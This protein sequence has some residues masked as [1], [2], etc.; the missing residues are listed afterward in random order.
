M[1]IKAI[2]IDDEMNN[3]DNLNVLLSG[4]CP[5]VEVVATAFSA[6][7]GRASILQY[8]PDLVFLDIQMPDK[9]GFELL[10]SLPQYDFEV[11]FVTAYDQ[12]GIQAVKFSAIDYLLKPINVIELQE[13]VSRAISK[14]RRSKQNLQLENLVQ[15]MM[16]QKEEHRIAL[17]TQKE[18][19]FVPTEEIIRCESSNNYTSFFLDSGEKIIV[20]KPIYDFEEIL[21]S[22]GFIRCHQSH[23]V[24]KRYIKSWV[25]E[26]GGY[27]MTENGTPIP[28][29][30]NKRELVSEA[31]KGSSI[32]TGRQ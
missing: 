22:Y 2:L 29:S 10:R 25:K 27:L 13:A 18:T 4:N 31:L 23:L 17:S 16:R 1:K 12:Y 3:L 8:Q 20:S 32:H 24:N 11:I 30:R 5:E 7:Q 19:R 14:S 26:D 6:E 9:N 21:S 15:V 28:V